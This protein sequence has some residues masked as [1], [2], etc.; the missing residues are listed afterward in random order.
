MQS[1]FGTNLMPG[2]SALIPFSYLQLTTTLPL[3][4]CLQCL[5][6]AGAHAA[7]EVTSF[8]LRNDT[9]LACLRYCLS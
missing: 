6:V 2:P 4:F 3:F 7:A 1:F 5:P 8:V 9:R